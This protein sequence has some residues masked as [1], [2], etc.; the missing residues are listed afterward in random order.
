[1]K[2]FRSNGSAQKPRVLL[3]EDDSDDAL[4]FRHALPDGCDL[5]IAEDGEEGLRAVIETKPHI[6]FLDLRLPK[7]CGEDVCK[8]IRAHEDPEIAKTPIIMFTSKSG[9]ADRVIGRV[10][11]AD[12]YLTKPCRPDDILKELCERLPFE[13]APHPKSNEILVIEDDQDDALLIRTMLAHDRKQSYTVH[14]AVTLKQGLEF[15]SEHTPDLI[16]S[17][18]GLPDSKGIG[19]FRQLKKAAP[20]TPI[21]LLTGHQDEL[22]AEEALHEGAQDFVHKND[23]NLQILS[24]AIRYAIER[25]ALIKK[26]RQANLKDPLTGLYNRPAFLALVDHQL[27]ISK[28][29]QKDFVMFYVKIQGQEKILAQRGQE[30]AVQSVLAATRILRH[31]FRD[32]DVLARVGSHEFAIAAVYCDHESAESLSRRLRRDA[33]WYNEAKHLPFEVNFIIVNFMTR[34]GEQVDLGY[35][36]DRGAA[37]TAAQEENGSEA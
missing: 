3:I 9:E 37:Q 24:R 10:I 26:A 14:C 20:E 33:E 17:D 19:T 18:L 34:A 25:Y 35:F 5:A 30:G 29:L 15:L 27:K 36:L 7:M 4:L 32:S 21:L 8:A 1:M 28:R 6:V 16:V 13:T 2:Q 22:M 31:S 23:M 12:A 11:G